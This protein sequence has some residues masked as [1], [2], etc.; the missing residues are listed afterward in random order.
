M[1]FW[2]SLSSHVTLDESP[3]VFEPPFL[4]LQS[5]LLP[6][7]MQASWEDK[8]GTE[9]LTHLRYFI[10]MGKRVRCQGAAGVPASIAPEFCRLL[11]AVLGGCFASSALL[12]LIATI[13]LQALFQRSFLADTVSCNRSL[14]LFQVPLQLESRSA[15]GPKNGVYIKVVS[16]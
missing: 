3:G 11:K 6:R 16:R 10:H 12:S 9:Y 5:E 2:S 14:H 13:I 4:H 8:R 7:P 1:R 15:L